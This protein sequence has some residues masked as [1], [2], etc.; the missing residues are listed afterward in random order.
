[1]ARD[2]LIGQ[3]K[4]L[5]D[6]VS[7]W[8]LSPELQVGLDLYQSIIGKLVD[9]P[10]EPVGSPFPPSAFV[11]EETAMLNQQRVILLE[12]QPSLADTT[13]ISNR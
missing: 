5:A 11:T 8:Y 3:F 10:E 13:F 6:S 12:S 4:K 2:Q 7:H 1:M 9:L